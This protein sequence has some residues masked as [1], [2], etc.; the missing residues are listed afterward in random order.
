[1]ER[2]CRPGSRSTLPP[3]PSRARRHRI[4]T[5]RSRSAISAREG[6]K[7]V[8]SDTFKLTIT[9]RQRRS[10][11][12]HGHR[13]SDDRGRHHLVVPGSG[14]HIHRCGQCQPDLYGVARH[15]IG[16]AE[17]A[18]VQRRHAHFHGQAASGLQRFPGAEGHGQRRFTF[19]LGHIQAHRQS[20][21]TIR[22]WW[23][24]LS[25]ISRWPRIRNLDVS[26]SQQARSRMWTAPA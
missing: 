16:A 1:M 13:R 6:S 10:D 20:P 2:P 25:P 3:A 19:H 12:E 4:M 11:R 21:S 9:P 22:P 23:R 24:H 5:G 18:Y 17:L 7:L 26:G 15:R 14:R 8:G